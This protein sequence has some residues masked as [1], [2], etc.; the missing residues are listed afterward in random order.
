MKYLTLKN[1]RTK[2][3]IKLQIKFNTYIFIQ[4]NIFKK[5]TI[6]LVSLVNAFSFEILELEIMK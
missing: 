1:A 2:S 4:I 3:N 5:I 6:Q